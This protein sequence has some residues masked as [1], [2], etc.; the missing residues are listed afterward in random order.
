MLTRAIRT[1]FVRGSAFL[2][3]RNYWSRPPGD[4]QTPGRA[5]G[6][7]KYLVFC[8]PLVVFARGS[9]IWKPVKTLVSGTCVTRDH[10]ARTL[11][12]SVCILATKSNNDSFDNSTNISEKH[13]DV[14][15]PLYFDYRKNHWA[16][17]AQSSRP[18]VVAN[19]LK[20]LRSLTV[21]RIPQIN[22]DSTFARF[23]FCSL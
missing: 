9:E 5:Y 18:R 3:R 7:S 16:I 8:F 10:V 19:G 4:L 22:S 6:S 14:V 11:R 2:N 13:N 15:Y 20:A 23:F 1:E 17:D 12:H 21:T